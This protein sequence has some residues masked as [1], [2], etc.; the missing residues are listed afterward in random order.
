MESE[1]EWSQRARRGPEQVL[2]QGGR[3]PMFRPTGSILQPCRIGVAA[4]GVL[5]TVVYGPRVSSGS[6]SAPTVRRGGSIALP[7][8]RVEGELSVEKALVRP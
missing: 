6:E 1:V 7:A 5:L 3:I 8:P 2:L 4:V